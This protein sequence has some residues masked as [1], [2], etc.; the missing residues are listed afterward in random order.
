MRVFAQLLESIAQYPFAVVGFIVLVGAWLVASLNYNKARKL[1]STIKE[2]PEQHRLKAIELEYKAAPRS[3]LSADQWLRHRQYLYVLVAFVLTL[4]VLLGLAALYFMRQDGSG[5]MS[6]KP[7]YG[8]YECIA[9]ETVLRECNLTPDRT[10]TALLSFRTPEH[11]TGG[12][13]DTYHG[14]LEVENGCASVLLINFFEIDGQ[15]SGQMPGVLK[16]CSL[17]EDARE[18]SGR[19]ESSEGAVKTFTM[20]YAGR[21]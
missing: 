11:G 13:I 7:R 14:S 8:P 3:G 12:I 15:S 10:G 21:Q 6:V 2:L 20:R 19:W 16:L 4:I 5:R 18:W 1:L 9:G 17:S